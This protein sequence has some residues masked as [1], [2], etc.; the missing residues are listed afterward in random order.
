MQYESQILS[1]NPYTF[2]DKIHC[3]FENVYMKY[4]NHQLKTPNRLAKIPYS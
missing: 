2:S 1:Q 3:F 4:I